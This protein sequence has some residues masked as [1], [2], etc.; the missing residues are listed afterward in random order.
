MSHV[1]IFIIRPMPVP[2]YQVIYQGTVCLN[3]NIKLSKSVCNPQLNLL[4][5]FE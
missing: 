1:S 3:K 5:G 4:C 2:I